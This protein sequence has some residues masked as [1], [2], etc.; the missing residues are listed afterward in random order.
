DGTAVAFAAGAFAAGAA[1][2]FAAGAFAVS[3]S[4]EPHA[5]AITNKSAI[6]IDSI[7]LALSNLYL[8]M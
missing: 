1:G 7:V 3:V 5:T 8:D 4:D 6:T 2:A